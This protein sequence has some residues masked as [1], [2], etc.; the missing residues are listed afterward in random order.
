VAQ[1]KASVGRCPALAGAAA[2]FGYPEQ[3]LCELLD[4]VE[5]PEPAP[6]NNPR[7]RPLGLKALLIRLGVPSALL[8]EIRQK[9]AGGPSEPQEWSKPEGLLVKED[10]DHAAT[11]FLAKVAVDRNLV[12]LAPAVARLEL[13]VARYPSPLDHVVVASVVDGG[14][15]KVDLSSALDPETAQ[16]ISQEAVFEHA[17]PQ[18]RLPRVRLIDHGH[19]R[20]GRDVPVQGHVAA[21]LCRAA[22][23]RENET[24]RL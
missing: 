9:L 8:A 7:V 22:K 19:G 1:K 4:R 3:C 6:R 5:A 23:S 17:L 18:A 21:S 11:R 2:P 10:P 14:K 24:H 13:G 20:L 15:E 16:E 12:P